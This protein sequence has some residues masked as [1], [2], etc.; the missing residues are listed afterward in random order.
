MRATERF[1]VK[2]ALVVHL[3]VCASFAFGQSNDVEQAVTLWSIGTSDN[4]TA[5]FALATGE[6]SKYRAPGCFVVG[7]SDPAED[8]PYVQPGTIDGGWAPGT[9]Q[10]FEAWFGLAAPPQTACRVLLD[11]V[12]THSVDPPKLRVRVN[13]ATWEYQTPHGAGDASV[14]GDPAQGREHLIVI[15]IPVEALR[16]G[17]NVLAVTT[18]EGSWV[19]WDA[20]SFEAPRG[21]AIASLQGGTEVLGVESKSEPAILRLADG[22]A[23]PVSLSIRHLGTALEAT[24]QIGDAAPRAISLRAGTQMVQA[25]VPPVTQPTMT[26]VVVRRAP[27]KLAPGTTE[28]VIRSTGRELAR[29]E[30]VLQP[31]RKREIHLIHQ[32][33]LDIGFTHTQDEVLRRQVEYLRLAM[34]YIDETK[35]YPEGARFVWH[36]E[37]MWAVDEFMRIASDEEKARFV[38]ACRRQQIHL[39]V[40]YAQAMTGMYTEEEIFE[41][42]GAAKRFEA[43][44][45]V[46][47]DSAMQSDVPGYTWGLAAALGHHGV[48]YMSIGP[49]HFHRM[50]YTFDWGD[51]PFWWVSPS[52]KH[53]ILFWMCGDGYAYFHGHA[54]D[55]SNIFNYLEGLE[56]KEY[57]YEMALMRYCI[58]GDN[59]PPRRELSDFVKEWNEKYVTPTLVIARNSGALKEFGRRYGDE[60]EVVS[61]DFTP[62]W[63]DGSASTSMA[64]GVNRRSCEELAQVQKLWAMINP[65]LKLSR[66]FDRAWTKM[67]MYDEHTWGAHNSISQPDGA[68]AV[69]QDRYK[70]QFAFDGAALTRRLLE[71]VTGTAS[72]AAPKVIDVHNT[73]SWA[74]DDL[75]VLTPEQSAAG[76]RVRDAEGSLVPSQR[77]ASGALAFRAL[78]VPPLGSRR[79]SLEAGAAHSTGRSRATEFSLT[80]EHITLRINPDTGAIQSLR[81]VSIDAELVDQKRGVGLNDYLYILGRDPAQNRLTIEGG[82]VVHVE[83]PGPLVATLRV[84]S[85]APGCKRLIRRIRLVD[86]FDH[87]ELLNTT[88]KLME[89]RPEGLYF[90]FPFDIPD[91]TARVD[92]PWAVVE[93]EKDQMQGANRNYFC[94]QRFVDLSG[95]DY[96]VTWVPIDAPMV[97]FDPIN[98]AAAGGRQSWRTHIDP[99]AYLHSWT[100][101]NHWETNYKADQEGLISFAYAIRPHGGGYDAAS[102][103]RFG[104]AICQPL[105]AVAGDPKT[106]LA[107]SLLQV[108]GDGVVVTNVRPTRDGRGLTVRLFNTA[109]GPRS[110]GL[111]W[112][113]PYSESWLSNPMEE[114]LAPMPDTL[115]LER[116][117]IMTLRLER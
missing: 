18:L 7:E 38:D 17:D 43:D 113:S 40:L 98:I 68:F 107:S 99:D 41:L 100:M 70:Q 28:V 11:F 65:G 84:E 69:Q 10:T 90:N 97:Q 101:N 81:H 106:P 35:D 16:A 77:L 83:D 20:L 47:I 26:E 86:G 12:D 54:L 3:G 109:D 75:V 45:G 52:G 103:Q 31:V 5:E 116:F 13:D 44:Y 9:P 95:S 23:Q 61:G 88:D 74:R 64:T 66:D 63:E 114:K 93:V 87:V 57:P 50:G 6:Y 19:L 29:A 49:N 2:A 27:D 96:G 94:V 58:G 102:V 30:L 25:L 22:P 59:G 21:T 71:Q 1:S 115:N 92:V 62:Y 111:K 36:P 46:Q 73:S 78:Q 4:S 117:E 34:Q 79:Y 112:R 24:L 48:E 82:V 56:R 72:T 33:H 105:L 91:A 39:D 80:N 89:R 53:R 67:I 76:D 37:G 14:F 55:E 51:K 85:D 32:T 110:A 42:M 104:R 60:L 8:W 108:S 15:D